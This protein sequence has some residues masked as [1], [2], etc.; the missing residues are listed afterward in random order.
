M[1]IIFFVQHISYSILTSA[2]L[3]FILPFK[4]LNKLMK[5]SSVTANHFKFFFQRRL[6][7]CCLFLFSTSNL[8]SKD[9][10]ISKHKAFIIKK[11]KTYLLLCTAKYFT[12]LS[13]WKYCKLASYHLHCTCWLPI[14]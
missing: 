8:K 10:S 5:K 6:V 14:F 12:T 1:F 4:S 11:Y 3:K 7:Q 2:Y 9:T 13:K